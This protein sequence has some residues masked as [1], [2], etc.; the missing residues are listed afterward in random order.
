MPIQKGLSAFVSYQ[1][2][3]WESQQQMDSVCI[4]IEDMTMG[5]FTKSCSDR[6][7]GKLMFNVE[8]EGKTF[9]ETWFYWIT[10]YVVFVLNSEVLGMLFWELIREERKKCSNSDSI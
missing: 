3:A 8:F 9:L 4:I 6:V 5:D 2:I 10:E 7:G 1:L